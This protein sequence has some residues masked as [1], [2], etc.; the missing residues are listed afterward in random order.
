ME[1][2]G[3]GAAGRVLLAWL[4]EEEWEALTAASAER[5]GNEGKS[6]P[7]ELRVRLLQGREEGCAASSGK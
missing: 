2:R 5:F 6:D 7:E 4:P 1:W 3:R